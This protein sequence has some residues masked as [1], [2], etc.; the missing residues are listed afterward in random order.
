VLDA[1]LFDWGD[2]LMRWAPEPEFLEDGHRAGLAAIG[3]DV[4]PAITARFRDVYLP[5][6]FAQG[7]IEEI[8]Y[9]GEVRALLGEFGIDVGDDDLL[10]F[11]EAE[12]AAWA[13]A[14]QLAATTH[15]LLETL[16]ER[17][18][19]LGL[20]SNAI[21]PPDL[22]HRDLEQLGVAQRLDVAVFSS[23]VGRRKP[24][25][26]IFEVALSRLGIEPERAL[27][28]GDS[29]PN[30]VAGA[31]ALGMT[32]CQALWFVADS[33]EEPEPDFRAFTQM[34]VLTAVSRA[35]KRGKSQVL[36]SATNV[37]HNPA[38]E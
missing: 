11:L 2:T 18:L 23:E 12:H 7:V 1:V 37:T 20:V 21:D 30:D 35:S 16:R 29:V 25:P 5:K 33:Q 3:R 24:D 22:L 19:K 38:H 28:V 13:P 26:S 4:D 6:F 36:R 32:T 8:E 9:P 34:D 31:Q 10:R 27:M 14:R 17:G 15:A